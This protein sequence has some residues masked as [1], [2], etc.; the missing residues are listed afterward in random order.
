MKW[1]DVLLESARE[2]EAPDRY[3]FWAGLCTISAVARKN[4]Y[5]QRGAFY[6]LYPNI[7]VALVSARSGLRKGIPIMVAKRLVTDLDSVRVISGC[8]SI[9][10]LTKELSLQQ[11]FRSGAVVNEAQG[12]MISD[13][14][15]SFITE[16]PRALTYLTALHNTH[17]HEESWKKRLKGSPLEELKSPCLTLLVASNEAL[18]ESMVK[19]KDIEGGFIARTF[20]VHESRKK[21]INDL[22]YTDEEITEL[23]EK[24]AKSH[25]FLMNRLREISKL[26][27]KM[28]LSPK[29]TIIYHNW[30]ADLSN[31]DFDD[32][33]GSIDRLGDQV[34]KV[35]MLISIS[36][37][38]SLVISDSDL[39][40]AIDAAQACIINTRVI[41]MEKENGEIN[42]V[43]EKILKELIKAPEQTL[44]R[45]YLMMKTH[46]ESSLMDRALDTLVQRGALSEP[47]RNSKKEICY[48]MRRE[49]FESYVKFQNSER[50]VN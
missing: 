12:L 10:A 40:T 32:K 44:T 22:I 3:F 6:K 14:F 23:L 42:P 17:E 31:T 50:K 30:Y 4:V 21:L 26:S 13:E 43:I 24:D 16:D 2:A 37:S 41:S 29:A 7:F 11:T 8:N 9:Q 46:V 49:I 15:E 33:T 19:Q 25:E 36:D 47:K 28:T 39:I 18:F 35:A 27:G 45:K 1:L 5:L 34:L 20:I 38:D 48:Q